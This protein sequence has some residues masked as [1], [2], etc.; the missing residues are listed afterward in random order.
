MDIKKSLKK[1]VDQ[2]YLR[3]YSNT[4]PR[5]RGKT[6]EKLLKKVVD[7]IRQT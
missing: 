5:E 2:Y 3:W 4:C 1:G 7:K 6:T